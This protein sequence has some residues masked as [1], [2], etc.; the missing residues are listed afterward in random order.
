MVDMQGQEL[1]EVSGSLHNGT[2][3]LR[4]ANRVQVLFACARAALDQF[5][6]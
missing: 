2:D 5:P 3:L 4:D 6:T 1:Q